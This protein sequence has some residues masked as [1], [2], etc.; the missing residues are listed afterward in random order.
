MLKVSLNYRS[1]RTLLHKLQVNLIRCDDFYMTP[2]WFPHV[3]LCHVFELR[4]VTKFE[5][6][7]PR[8]FFKSSFCSFEE[9]LKN[10]S[11]NRIWTWTSTM[12]L[13][14][15]SGWALRPTGSWLSCGLIRSLLMM[16]IDLYKNLYDVDTPK[17]CIGTAGW[18]KVW[19]QVWSSQFF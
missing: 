19:S 4:V 12:P 3:Q 11:L 8:S 10:S 9:G 7:E 6:C 1:I 18:N 2:M 17:L 16:G 14:C 5:V 15:S 13:Q